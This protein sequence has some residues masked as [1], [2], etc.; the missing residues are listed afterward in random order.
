MGHSHQQIAVSYRQKVYANCVPKIGERATKRLLVNQAWRLGLFIWSGVFVVLVIAS[1]GRAKGQFLWTILG[2]GLVIVVF[3]AAVIRTRVLYVR[4]VA[5]FL[6]IDVRAARHVPLTESAFDS[7]L[8]S[9]QARA[10]RRP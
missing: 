7:W 4:E 1:G 9:Q 10:V 3:A 5:K 2:M 8:K 6:S